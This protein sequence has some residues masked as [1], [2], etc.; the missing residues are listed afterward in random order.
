M[1][2]AQVLVGQ[3]SEPFLEAALKSVGWVDKYAVVNTHADT[4]GGRANREIV[5]RTVPVEKLRY[6]EYHSTPETFSFAEARNQ[7]LDMIPPD[8]FVLW[9]DADD[10]HT[11]ELENIVHYYLMN[12]ADS[13]TADFMHF[14]V[15][16]D[17]V[18]AVF[19]RELVY[20]KTPDT[21]WV[22]RVH[23]KLVTPRQRP[24]IAEYRWFHA[25]Y[26]RGQR[27]VFERWK[28]YSDLVGDT[29]HYD[30]QNP[31]TIIEDRVSVARR[32]EMEWPPVAQG[33]IEQ[34]PCCPHPLK[35]EQPFPPP[36]VGLVLIEHR[37]DPQDMK[38]EMLRTLTDTVG[39]YEVLKLDGNTDSLAV[40]LNKGFDHFRLRG[41]DYVGWIHP[42]HR[43]D[44]P[45]WLQ[46]LLH[47]LRCWPK[48]AKVCAANTRDVLPARLIDGH[49]QCY[50]MR[51]SVLGEVGLFDESFLMCGGHEDWDIH[52]RIV[53]A[54]YRVCITPRAQVHHAGMS[55]RSKDHSP[56]ALAA[57]QNN[58]ARYM[59]K[60]GT[61]SPPV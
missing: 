28:F 44:D 10:I 50:L 37:D 29:H 7:A 55:T 58:A 17:A 35:D 12:G 56:E 15:Y 5:M 11:P 13:I 8:T 4:P 53:N 51:C 40:S 52:M 60:W 20:K 24:V 38:A 30:G 34:V 33:A 2:V 47:E 54:G 46:S 45:L 14:V 19:P 6:A 49:E 61:A 48:V 31:D 59:A 21:L 32:L 16:C 39:D 43:F 3:F 42:D 18:Q 57:A 9:L 41:F 26:I 22:G 25:S 1:I 27:S 23:E 36:K